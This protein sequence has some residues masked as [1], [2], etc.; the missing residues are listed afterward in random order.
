MLA[1][2]REQRALLE[3]RF[4]RIAALERRIFEHAYTSFDQVEQE[5]LAPEHVKA[6]L[7]AGETAEAAN[8]ARPKLKTGKAITAAFET[9]DASQAKDKRGCQ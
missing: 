2:Q 1:L 5:L 8:A 3:L 4:A 9:L 6:L 7:A